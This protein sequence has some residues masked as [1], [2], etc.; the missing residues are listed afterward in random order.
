VV[1]WTSVGFHRSEWTT[2]TA[3]F[4]SVVDGIL[5]AVTAPH[6]R[7]SGAVFSFNGRFTGWLSVTRLS[8]LGLLTSS[9]SATSQLV[10]SKRL[11]GNRFRE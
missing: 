2:K 4:R 1:V 7:S 11:C 6:S 5:S 3:D 9:T 10:L 8:Q